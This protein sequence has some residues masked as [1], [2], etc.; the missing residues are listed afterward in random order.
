M[1]PRRAVS[2]SILLVLLGCEGG[3]AGR[4]S[5]VTVGDPVGPEHAGQY[6]EGPVDFAGS[7]YHNACEPYPHAIRTI[8]GDMLA[9][10]SNTVATPGSL[11]D[12]CIEVSTG[13][14]RTEVLRVVTYGV[15]NADG[16]LDLSPE[17]YDALHQ[18]EYP[19]AMTWR[20]V[21]CDNGEPIHIQWK[22]D[23]SIWWTS[24]WVRNP[25]MAIDRVEVRNA[26]FTSYRALE[27][28]TDGSYTEPSG[29]GDGPFTLRVT[30]VTG[31]SYE[32][33]MDEIDGGAL[34]RTAGNIPL[35]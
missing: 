7:V 25:T 30:G 15:S 31:A 5:P 34:V 29:F 17:A 3:G 1:L 35:E 19:R 8:T 14:G 10:V 4:G 13:A 16:D 9:G 24:L 27:L 6:H 33:A 2:L 12:A 32:I 11:C 28:A 26:K 21:A 23:S 20:L 18:G 22:Q